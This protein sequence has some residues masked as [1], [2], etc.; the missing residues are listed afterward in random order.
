MRLTD[1]RMENLK[2]ILD[3]MCRVKPGTNL[4]IFADDYARSVTLAQ[5]LM[6]LANSMGAEAAMAVF[7]RRSHPAEE[8]PRSVAS[9]MKAADVILGVTEG[10]EIGHSTARKEAG[11]AGIRCVFVDAIDGEDHL[12]TP[13]S[14]E[15]LDL[16]RKR[17][18]KICEIESKGK[19]VRLT[20]PHGTDLTFSIEGRGAISLSPLSDSPIVVAPFYAEAA[21][22]PVEETTEGV[23]VF[24]SFI[25]GWESMLRKPIRF[26]VKKGRAQVETVSSDIPADAE[27][28][29]E[30][31]LMDKMACT[32]AAE[33]GIGT[34]HIMP[35]DP[36]GHI[37]DKA[38]LGHV[39]I[40]VGRNYDL[41]GTSDSIIH[42]DGDM[43]QATITIDD[44]TIME[45]GQ[46][47]I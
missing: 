29:K 25:V 3:K 37:T 38:R 43:T 8:P 26:E 41:G 11:E 10:P 18:A 30:T 6:D 21:I 40:A 46:L 7:K 42:R 19:R 23:L 17:S 47:K 32:C 45:N 15:D 2:L 34:S 1:I 20:T 12:Q 13:I 27:R 33:F 5:D 9:A 4:F 44:V 35:G 22:A 39:H 14:F 36:V 28:F 31:L 24:D 16:I